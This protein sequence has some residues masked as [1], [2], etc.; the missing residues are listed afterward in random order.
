MDEMKLELCW[1]LS[2]GNGQIL[3][4]HPNPSGSAT[5]HVVKVDCGQSHY[6]HGGPIHKCS[7]RLDLGTPSGGKNTPGYEMGGVCDATIK[8]LADNR[9]EVTWSSGQKEEL[10]LTDDFGALP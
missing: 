2:S 10:N 9:F 6:Y 7:T 3:H 1:R 8:W 5:I 4:S